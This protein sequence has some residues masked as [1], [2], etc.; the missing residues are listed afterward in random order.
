MRTLIVTLT[1]NP[2]APATIRQLN[3]SAEFESRTLAELPSEP[4]RTVALFDTVIFLDADPGIKEMRIETLAGEI[5]HPSRAASIVAH[6]RDRFHFRGQAFLCRIPASKHKASA[7]REAAAYKI[8]SVLEV[9][10]RK[11]SAEA[12]SPFPAIARA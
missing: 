3:A 5:T 7:R 10:L 11:A 9:L 12:A 1:D 2:V 8:A 4:E 6:A